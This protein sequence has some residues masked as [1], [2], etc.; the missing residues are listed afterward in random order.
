VT[1][2]ELLIRALGSDDVLVFRHQLSEFCPVNLSPTSEGSVII[3]H[4]VTQ[5]AMF[6]AKN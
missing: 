2:L 4:H 6:R 3:V 1:A 5:C